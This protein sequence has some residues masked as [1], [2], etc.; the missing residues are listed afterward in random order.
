MVLLDGSRGFERLAQRSKYSLSQTK[1]SR[2]QRP[3]FRPLHACATPGSRNSKFRNCPAKSR[4]DPSGGAIYRN[5]PTRAPC[6]LRQCFKE[7]RTY[8]RPLETTSMTCKSFFLGHPE[9]AWARQCTWTE[10][11]PIRGH[12]GI[13]M[14]RGR[15]YLEGATRR[16]GATNRKLLSGSAQPHSFVT[17]GRAHLRPTMLFPRTS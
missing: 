9:K 12:G 7:E 14:G 10:N 2:D 15:A 16:H 6:S 8:K 4:R 17:S 11:A 3:R 5:T 1:Q 13:V